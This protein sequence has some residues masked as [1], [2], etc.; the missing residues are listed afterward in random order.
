MPR[1]LEPAFVLRKWDLGESDQIVNLLT[2]GRGRVK[3]VAKGS[4]RS[5][6]RFGGLLSPFLLIQV[7]YVQ[8]PSR[9]L[10]R[11]ENCS[12]LR[13]FSGIHED[14]KRLLIGCS[15]IEVTEKVLPEGDS[16]GAFFDLMVRGFGC[17]EKEGEV[18]PLLA[19]FL[20]K[21]LT[22]SGM[23]PQLA[24]CVHCLRRLG[25]SGVF[26]FSVPQG[27]VVCGSCARRGTVTHLVSSA[28]LGLLQE[29]LDKPMCEFGQ[30]NTPP[31]AIQEAEKILSSFLSHHV[32]RELRSLRVFQRIF[33]TS[34]RMSHDRTE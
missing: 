34:N 2:R 8:T 5:K 10:V 22:L 30:R 33:E 19:A 20:L 29:W 24:V 32:G 18:S 28:T 23:Q 14:L 27:G 1:F 7:E 17:L 11:V 4:K 21:I 25:P 16:G 31:S 13:S 3:G 9:E 26:G 6:K 12:L 15:L